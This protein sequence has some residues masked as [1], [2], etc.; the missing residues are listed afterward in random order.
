MASWQRRTHARTLQSG[1]ERPQKHHCNWQ[2]NRMAPFEGWRRRPRPTTAKLHLGCGWLEAARPLLFVFVAG[3][4]PRLARPRM[5][6][7]MQAG[8]YWWRHGVCTHHLALTHSPSLICLP[9]C[10]HCK[11]LCHGQGK[12][13]VAMDAAAKHV[14]THLAPSAV[15]HRGRGT[16]D[17]RPIS[18]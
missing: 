1:A 6:M 5:G 16:C 8:T 7:H 10:A 3:E 4:H 18:T 2:A 12:A 17:R 14:E 15:A 9:D 13:L 11:G